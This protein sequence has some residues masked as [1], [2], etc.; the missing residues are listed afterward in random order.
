GIGVFV[1]DKRGTGKSEGTYTQDFDLLAD[2]AAAALT[3]GKEIAGPLAREVGF[4]G[5]SQAGWIEPLAATKVK[6]DFVIVGFGLAESPLA[7]DR[8]EVFD[9]L[10]RAGYGDDVI[11]K[12]REITTATGRVIASHFKEGYDELDAVRE[13]YRKEPSY[14]KINGE[15]TGMILAMPNW[16]S[17][18]V[19]PMLEVGTP[20]TYDPLPALKAYQGPH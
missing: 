18:I 2:D 1:Y 7:E 13:K 15:F 14:P 20:M 16:L 6:T 9:D 12:A 4:Q 19:G 17:R 3:K 8:D 11:E 10:R 5:G